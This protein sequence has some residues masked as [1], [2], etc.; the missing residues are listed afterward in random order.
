L[1]SAPD[2]AIIC[3]V[4]DGHAFPIT[5]RE[6]FLL[7]RIR[8]A[9]SAGADWIQIRE[10]D[11]P[12]K[13]LLALVRESLRAASTIAP[14][15]R[16]F[17]NDRLDVALAAGAAGVQLGSESIPAGASIRWWRAGNAPAGFLVGVS[18]HSLEEVKTAESAGADCVFFGP[19]FDTPSKRIFGPPQGIDLL[20]AVCR[21]VS[22]PVIAI[23]G[24]N[25]S[26]AADCIRAGAKGVAAIRLFQEEVDSV[27][28]TNFVS[29]IHA[30]R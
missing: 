9:L 27:A 30:C 14:A 11:L 15:A 19:I 28:L 26:N 3:Y 7:D 16:I 1:P 18:C 10:K 25:E 17:L 5:D 29:A 6:R 12:A 8:T 20:G 4:T 2:R 24:I 22:L 21:S 23:G 13:R